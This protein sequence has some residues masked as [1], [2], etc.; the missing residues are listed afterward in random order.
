MWTPSV[1]AHSKLLTGLQTSD[2]GTKH[3]QCY[4]VNLISFRNEQRPEGLYSCDLYRDYWSSDSARSRGVRTSGLLCCA[5]HISK[6]QKAVWISQM[7]TNNFLSE[8][9]WRMKRFTCGPG[10][11]SS[12]KALC[13]LMVAAQLFLPAGTAIPLRINHRDG[14]VSGLWASP[15]TGDIC[16]FSGLCTH[17]IPIQDPTFLLFCPSAAVI[18]ALDLSL[19]TA[20]GAG[21]IVYH[22]SLS[23]C[24][25]ADLQVWAWCTPS[26]G[27]LVQSGP[28]MSQYEWENMAQ[29]EMSGPCS[30]VK[31]LLVLS[32]FTCFLSGCLPAFLY[33]FF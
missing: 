5:C 9:A 29:S 3:A 7:I 10:Q 24:W 8:Y 18:L 19:L 31:S 33:V 32:L 28:Q 17:G 16:W 2:R 23:V 22:T 12:H 11:H 4:C 25:P 13:I 1:K 6:L 15:S 20:T 21:I 14:A 27:M 30:E 26:P